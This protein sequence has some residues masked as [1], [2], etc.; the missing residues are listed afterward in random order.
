MHSPDEWHRP[1]C[2]KPRDAVGATA[3][4][5]LQAETV[6]TLGGDYTLTG[7]ITNMRGVIPLYCTSFTRVRI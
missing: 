2:S 4:E 5:L 1:T 7:C 6:A 3:E